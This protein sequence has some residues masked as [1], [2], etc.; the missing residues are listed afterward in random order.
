MFEVAVLRA[1]LIDTASQGQ[2][3]PFQKVARSYTFYQHGLIAAAL[4]QEADDPHSGSFSVRRNSHPNSTLVKTAVS[5]PDMTLFS[6]KQTL[7]F[8]LQKLNKLIELFS[9]NN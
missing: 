9:E 6:G 1:Y 5:S 7:P 8:L 4:P 2:P 3:S